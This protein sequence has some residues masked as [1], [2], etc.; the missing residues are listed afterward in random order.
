MKKGFTTIELIIAVGLLA[1]VMVISG[2]IFKITIEAKRRAGAISE[3]TRNFR[4]ITDQINRDFAGLSKDGY[5]VIR[6]EVLTG[7]YY[8]N[9]K[10]EL[11]NKPTGGA[12]RRDGI[13]FFS[14]GDF[15][16]SKVPDRK[17]NMALISYSLLYE[18]PN[19]GNEEYIS[20][21]IFARNREMSIPGA[22]IS[23]N[24]YFSD[25]LSE[26]KVDPCLTSNV[27][28]RIDNNN[29]TFELSDQDNNWKFF[30]GNVF[31]IRISWA[32]VVDA[33]GF[34]DWQPDAS[35]ALPN[36]DVWQSSYPKAIKFT[37]TLFDSQGIF[38]DGK[39]FTHIVYLDK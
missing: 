13:A 12:L 19:T 20:D 31:D 36:E 15:Q 34:I 10:Y 3:I 32:D 22:S 6:N 9:K 17:S 35:V 39:L 33:N 30:A 25:S 4:A 7:P 8:L 27:L 28:T 23:D 24:E 2:S 1:V 16:S 37:I 11:E 18:D 38:P 5:M 26:I 29:E 14:T 21:C